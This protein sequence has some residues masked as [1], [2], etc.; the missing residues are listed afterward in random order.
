MRPDVFRLLIIFIQT[1]VDAYTHSYTNP[2]VN[3][4][5]DVDANECQDKHTHIMGLAN[6]CIHTHTNDYTP[7]VNEQGCKEPETL[8]TQAGIMEMTNHRYT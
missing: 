6:G 1:N 4:S 7:H 5:T 3:K 8:Q 2:D